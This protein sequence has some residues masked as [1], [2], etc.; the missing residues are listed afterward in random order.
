MRYVF[1]T[2]RRACDAISVAAFGLARRSIADARPAILAGLP[3]RSETRV[4]R[5][6]LVRLDCSRSTA[7]P[8]CSSARALDSWCPAAAVG[9]GTRIAGSPHAAS[10]AIV[11]PALATTRSAAAY[12]LVKHEV[13]EVFYVAF[14]E[15]ASCHILETNA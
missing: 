6:S 14:A 10:E 13:A 8:D 4:A 9:R 12:A 7:A 15:T 5:V 2:R 3:N 11:P 1:G